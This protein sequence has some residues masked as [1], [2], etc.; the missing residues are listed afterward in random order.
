MSWIRYKF[1]SGFLSYATSGKYEEGINT[2]I[3]IPEHACS[4]EERLLS[5]IHSFV[6]DS[7]TS[8]DRTKL[9]ATEGRP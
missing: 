7:T 4:V 3:Q 1:I 9:D 2:N 6:D 8:P 5:S